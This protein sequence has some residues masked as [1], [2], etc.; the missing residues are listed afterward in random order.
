M[1]LIPTR[2]NGKYRLGSPPSLFLISEEVKMKETVENSVLKTDLQKS[3]KFSTV[4]PASKTKKKRSKEDDN[5]KRLLN[6]YF[7]D[8]VN[9]PLLKPYD[10]KRLS[11]LSKICEKKALNL[12]SNNSSEYSR[13]HTVSSLYMKKAG[14][15]RQAFIKSNLRLVISIAKRFS[16]KGL[17]FS[18]MIQEG[19]LGLI[20][21][22]EKF[23]HEKGYRFSTYGAWWIQ[24]Y[25]TRAIFEKTRVIKVP[26]Y[27]MEQ[28]NKVFRAKY[29]LQDKFERKPLNKEISQ[30]CGL[31]EDIVSTVLNGFDNSESLD[32]PLGDDENSRAPIDYLQDENQPDQFDFVRTRKLREL[33]KSSIA[34]LSE[35][36][37]TII[38]MRYG[39]DSPVNTLEQIGELMG[40]TRERIRQLEKEALS[41]MSASEYGT[42][43]YN[44]KKLN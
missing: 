5:D 7:K 22:I 25:I 27:V 44:Y 26:V 8:I 43:L 41:K 30:E 31:S 9:I 13:I 34:T 1:L 21:A 42:E 2:R 14:E 35:R 37:K 39:I 11:A 17:P 32:R 36:E 29:K 33:L 40:V 12:N 24:Q 6:D 16:R 10:E 3:E 4:L 18:D 19:N 23:D 20:R 28:Q 38:K 15:Y